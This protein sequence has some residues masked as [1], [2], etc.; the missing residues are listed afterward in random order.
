MLRPCGDRVLAG[1]AVTGAE[2][3]RPI[4]KNQPGILRR[5]LQLDRQLRQRIEV[6]K[7]CE[8]NLARRSCFLT[9]RKTLR[10]VAGIGAFAGCVVW[11]K[12][13]TLRIDE[14]KIVLLE[15]ARIIELQSGGTS[16]APFI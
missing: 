1:D 13:A 8:D 5:L 14:I 4:R 6:C 10:G 9:R 3:F 7:R 12:L 15:I 16:A 11:P 2:V